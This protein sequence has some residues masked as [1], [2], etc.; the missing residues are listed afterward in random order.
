MNL[1]SNRLFKKK[2]STQS[3]N[4][5]KFQNFKDKKISEKL[6]ERYKNKLHINE[7]T[8]ERSK[9]TGYTKIIEQL[10]PKL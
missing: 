5:V 7:L 3:N 1:K 2:K 6:S 8:S 10:S 9:S 4:I